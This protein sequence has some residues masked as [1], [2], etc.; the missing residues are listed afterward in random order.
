MKVLFKLLPFLVA[1]LLYACSTKEVAQPQITIPNWY[2]QPA[3][4]VPPNLLYG[5]GNG[6]SLELAKK[7]ALQ[8]LSYNLQLQ[9]QASSTNQSLATRNGNQVKVSS[10]LQEEI[11]LKA[12][13]INFTN[14]E[15]YKVIQ[16]GEQ[17]YIIVVTSYDDLIT[18]NKR[19]LEQN[20][21][22]INNS[23]KSINQQPPIQQIVILASN[24]DSFLK[25]ADSLN[26]LEILAIAYKSGAIRSSY[27]NEQ[28]QLLQQFNTQ[29]KLAKDNLILAVV[30]DTRWET[31]KK[32]IA[33]NLQQQGYKTGTPNNAIIKISG[34]E[35]TAELFN[36]KIK[37]SKIFLLVELISLDD[38]VIKSKQFSLKAT[39]LQSFE[40]ASKKAQINIKK[41]F[42][43]NLFTTL[44]L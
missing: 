33:E 22:I 11:K 9:V 27:L 41:E 28:Q 4:Y 14:V 13:K 21:S 40:E 35:Q 7:R 18:A 38:K 19:K 15:D 25:A 1:T 42:D 37:Q 31:A 24:K 30:G 8:N 10:S 29:E 44:G 5:S 23:L 2:L 20:L 16:Q 26:T 32:L 39:S 17:Y 36:G 3:N 12:K 43:D 34:S 6:L